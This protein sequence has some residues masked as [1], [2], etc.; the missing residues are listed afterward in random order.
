VSGARGRCGRTSRGVA[1]CSVRQ[2]RR[3]AR[4]PGL[5]V[6]RFGRVSGQTGETGT[7]TPSPGEARA[8]RAPHNLPQPWSPKLPA[9]QHDQRR[10]ADPGT[11]QSCPFWRCHAHPEPHRTTRKPAVEASAAGDMCALTVVRGWW[12]GALFCPATT[13]A[14]RL[15]LRPRPK[16]PKWF[17]RFCNRNTTT[18]YESASPDR[19]ILT[20]LGLVPRH[21]GEAMGT[22]IGGHRAQTHLLHRPI[23]RLTE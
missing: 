1:R 17:R 18:R 20:P 5:T 22:H 9:T 21:A 2:A 3:P 11:S 8:G 14:D 12:S 16:P 13:C 4:M 7:K 19:V 6:I 23:A 15:L 10:T